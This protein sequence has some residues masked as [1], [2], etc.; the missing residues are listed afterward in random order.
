MDECR[1]YRY[2]SKHSQKEMLSQ[3]SKTH[4][5]LKDLGFKSKKMHTSSKQQQGHLFDERTSAEPARHTVTWLTEA[6]RR[7]IAAARQTTM[8][9]YLQ[10]LRSQCTRFSITRLV[11]PSKQQSGSRM[12]TTCEVVP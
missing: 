4:F 6:A 3:F 5:P 11:V 12:D 9:H 8:L 7:R 10:S 1:L 2:E